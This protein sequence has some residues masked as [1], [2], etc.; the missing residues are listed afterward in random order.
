MCPRMKV[1]GPGERFTSV[2]VNAM[3]SCSPIAGLVE[4]SQIVSDTLSE[5]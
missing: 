1:R 5:R 2:G 3:L 4:R